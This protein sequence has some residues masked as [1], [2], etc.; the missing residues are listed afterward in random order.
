MQA[1]RWAL[2]H[3]HMLTALERLFTKAGY[4]T[5]RKNVLHK[6]AAVQQ[7]Y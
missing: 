7:P 4:R 3:E 5:H 1:P 6:V 2:A